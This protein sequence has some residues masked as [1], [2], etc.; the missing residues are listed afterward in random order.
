MEHKHIF[1]GLNVSDFE[2]MLSDIFSLFDKIDGAVYIA[3]MDSYELLYVNRYIQNLYGNNLVGKKCYQILYRHQSAPCSFCTNHLLVK[4]Q[5]PQ[6]PH[7]WEFYNHEMNRWYKCFDKAI[8]WHDGRVVRLQIALDITQQKQ[9]EQEKK[10][11]QSKLITAFRQ[12]EIGTLLGGIAHDFN[13]LVSGVTSCTS[14]IKLDIDQNHPFYEPLKL[15][16]AS[17]DRIS[18][19]T[20]KLANFSTIQKENFS[21]VNLNFSVK[22]VLSV[23]FAPLTHQFTINTHFD[24]E[25][26]SIKGDSQKLE[27]CIFHLILNAMEAMEQGGAIFIKTQNIAANENLEEIGEKS[28]SPNAVALSIRD[29]GNGINEYVRDQL[30][31]PFYTTKDINNHKGLG[32]A[33]VNEI[34]K[35]FGGKIFVTS[36]PGKGSDFRLVFPVLSAKVIRIERKEIHLNG[37]EIKTILFVDDEESLR[38]MC[39]KLLS[40]HGYKVFLAADGIEACKIYE[41]H[42]SEIDLIILDFNMPKQSGYVTFKKIQQINPLVK[43]LIVSG[44]GVNGQIHEVLQEGAIDFI[45]KPFNFDVLVEK[46]NDII[47]VNNREINTK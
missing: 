1:A 45:P 7:V 2:R 21:A 24:P 9:H 11:L 44:Y 15:I 35:Q 14:L 19:L 12:A 37:S 41:E 23:L 22:N 31:D 34:V 6:S 28:E 36:E 47:K 3:D 4:N 40:R 25:I 42:V 33:I 18:D 29:T 5:N 17:I 26:L 30:F 27:N 32:L 13:N 16:D 38:S 43:V 8:L 20:I 46:L 39:K 10:H